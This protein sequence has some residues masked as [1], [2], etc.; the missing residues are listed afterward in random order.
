M[1][2]EGKN[3]G[4]GSGIRAQ[5]QP[6]SGLECAA[7]PTFTAVALLHLK[8]MAAICVAE[9]HLIERVNGGLG[10]EAAIMLIAVKAR[11]VRIAADLLSQ[12]ERRLRVMSCPSAPSGIPSVFSPKRDIRRRGSGIR[13]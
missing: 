12:G 1:Y 5:R 10:P 6:E 3:G 13:W 2:G 8:R 4:I 7:E 11:F 9:G